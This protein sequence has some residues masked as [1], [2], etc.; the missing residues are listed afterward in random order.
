MVSPRLTLWPDY[1][2]VQIHSESSGGAEYVVLRSRS[3]HIVRGKMR[4][5]SSAYASNDRR[6]SESHSTNHIVLIR[7]NSRKWR[8]VQPLSGL[9]GIQ[10]TFMNVSEAELSDPE[11]Q[12]HLVPIL[13][14]KCGNSTI[15]CAIQ[16]WL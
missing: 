5:C 14:F 11:S 12:K 6:Q 16:W 10:L 15:R 13:Q 9:L 4:K 2:L 7:I 1:R 3:V 8:V